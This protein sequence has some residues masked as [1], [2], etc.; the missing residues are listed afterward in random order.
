M[1]GETDIF[2]CIEMSELLQQVWQQREHAS[3]PQEEQSWGVV[4][5]E[6][7]DAPDMSAFRKFLHAGIAANK[8]STYRRVLRMTLACLEEVCT[9]ST[10]HA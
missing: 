3:S 2:D 5:A 1:D 6:L 9:P 7:L 4:E 10:A 8:S